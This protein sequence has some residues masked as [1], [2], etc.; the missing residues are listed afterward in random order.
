MSE[1]LDKLFCVI[2]ERISK[3]PKN[4]YTYRLSVLGKGYVAKKVGEEATEVVVASLNGTKNDVI[5]ETA[6]LLYHLWVLLALNEITPKE[7]YE[8]LQ[9]RMK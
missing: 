6:D 5:C 2:R 4:S 9:R 1:V 8:E 3:K 7:V